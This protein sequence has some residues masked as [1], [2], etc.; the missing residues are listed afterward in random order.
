MLT[1]VKSDSPAILSRNLLVEEYAYLVRPI[2]F[3]VHRRL[4]K[5]I[6]VEDLEGAGMIGLMHAC[7]H[8]ERAR[9]FLAYAKCCIRGAMIDSVRGKQYRE[10]QHEHAAH[11]RADTAPSILDTLIE[12]EQARTMIHALTPRQLKVVEMR[13][14]EDRKPAAIRAQLHIGKSGFQKLNQRAQA[15]ARKVVAIAPSARAVERALKAVA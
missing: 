9:D 12:D 2:A 10:S 7:D 4:P 13:V 5:Q 11:E 1:L 15:A 3:Q 14:V 6:D 8:P